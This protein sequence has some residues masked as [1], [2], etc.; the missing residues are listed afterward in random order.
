MSPFIFSVQMF[1]LMAGST[2]G[3]AVPDRFGRKWSFI[4][5]V[6]LKYVF[7]MAAGWSPTSVWLYLFVGLSF[8]MGMV[9]AL[10]GIIIA[11]EVLDDKLRQLVSMTQLGLYAVGYMYLPVLAFYLPNWRSL[12]Y[13]TA[14]VGFLTMP[15]LYFIVESPRWLMLKGREQEGAELLQK[16][17]EI[18]GVDQSDELTELFEDSLE[19]EDQNN[20]N[21]TEAGKLL[22][23]NQETNSGDAATTVVVKMSPSELQKS[24]EMSYFDLFT[25][26]AL[27]YRIV[28]C[29]LSWASASFS[30]YGS[31]F[32]TN[33]LGGNR[34][35]NCFI[36]GAAE[37]PGI[38]MCIYLLGRIGGRLSYI[39]FT[40]SSAF[41]FLLTAMFNQ[42]SQPGMLVCAMAAKMM[43]S[44][45]FNVNYS[46]T[47]ELFPTMLRNQAYGTCSF[48]SRIATVL[49]PY[50][51]YLGKVYSMSIPYVTM[52]FIAFIS[53]GLVVY[54]PDTKGEHI[55]NTME[56]IYIQE[57][58]KDVSPMA[59]VARCSK[60]GAI[61][62]SEVKLE[63]A[64]V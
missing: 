21:K 2:L 1:A 33:E 35:V 31:S 17:A 47:A 34:F 11:N 5:T 59:T 3:A 8:V 37:I 15:A 4:V 48:F 61:D 54:L 60:S 42:V 39:F 53:V 36:S 9:Q 18:N 16:I 63:S 24:S 50:L 27:R 14:I 52:S 41:F 12:T 10:V 13:A 30:F 7:T 40:A 6:V 62:A 64:V 32:N 25:L 19:T 22:D 49:A 45:A 51:L 56:D 20:N 55:P 58:D 23:M 46:Y 26:P 29:C 57:R 28:I 43:V 38:I 44:G